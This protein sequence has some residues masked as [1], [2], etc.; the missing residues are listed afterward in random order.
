MKKFKEIPADRECSQIWGNMAKRP[1]EA[2]REV[3][4]TR[5][6]SELARVTAYVLSTKNKLF[7]KNEIQH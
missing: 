6:E 5:E 2:T 4:P 7:D 1:V 3:K